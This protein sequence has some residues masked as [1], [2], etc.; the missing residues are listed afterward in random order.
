MISI[1]IPVDF[2]QTGQLWNAAEFELQLTPYNVFPATPNARRVSFKVNADGEVQTLRGVRAG[3]PATLPAN[4][5][6]G[7]LWRSGSGDPNG[8]IVGSPGDLWSDQAGGAQSLYT[9]ESGVATSAGWSPVTL[10]SYFDQLAAST[11]LPV[12]NV[13]L[14]SLTLTPRAGHRFL[15]NYTGTAFDAIVA[16]G[17]ATAFFDLFVDGVLM[18]TAVASIP[19]NVEYDSVAIVFRTAALTNAPHVIEIRARSND[20][21][22][23]VSVP[24]PGNSNLLV[25]EVAA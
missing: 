18:S 8:T 6:T 21:T 3:G 9:K 23:Q 12:A 4:L 15:I 22:G 25:Q 16:A 11:V 2:P 19:N 17:V 7:A 20:A 13:V 10:P 5:T 14:H 24:I 1:Q